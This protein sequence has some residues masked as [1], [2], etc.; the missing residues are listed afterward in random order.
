[1][2]FA[3]VDRE[4]TGIIIILGKIIIVFSLFLQRNDDELLI[5]VGEKGEGTLPNVASHVLRRREQTKI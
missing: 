1:M 3:V 5:P 2:H 4:H